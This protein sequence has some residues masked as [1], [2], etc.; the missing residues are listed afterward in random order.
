MV[1][2]LLRPT[3]ER[4]LAQIIIEAGET[5]RSIEILGA[6]SK[7]RYGRPVQAT[8]PIT[9]RNFRGLTLYEP[10]EMVVSARAGS[11]IQAIEAELAKH[12]QHFA[13]EPLDLGPML[14]EQ[15]GLSTI[16]G[17]IATNLSGPR[18]ILTGAARDHVLGLRAINGR[19]EAFK[20]GGRVMKNVTGYDL[21]RTLSGSWGTLAAFT[22][23]TLKV[24]PK[25]EETRTLLLFGQPDDIAIEILCG[26]MATPCEVSGTVHLHASL[27]ARLRNPALRDTGESITALR[28]ENFSASVAYRAEQLK[29]QFAAYGAISEL[30]HT[31]SLAFW[32]E[33][34]SLSFLTGSTDPVWRISTAPKMGP[35]VV[36]A[37]ASYMSCNVAYDWSGGLIWLEVPASADAGAADIRRVIATRGGHATL[38]RAPAKVRAEVDVF[39]PLEDGP[40]RLSH[41]IKSAFDP[42]GVLNP[43]RMYSTF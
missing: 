27:V 13:F 11:P 14:G 33:L 31:N 12:N 37:I 23:L 8:A 16:G 34:R 7:R 17:V 18:R 19:G 24:V 10:S 35:R 36:Q 30:D 5:G 42:H 26:A 9:L 38:V 4:G 3:D 22:E 41:G 6:G 1:Q 43:G 21:A 28:I 20:W 39:Q 25:A 29:Q 15:A 2:Q 40:M 32:S